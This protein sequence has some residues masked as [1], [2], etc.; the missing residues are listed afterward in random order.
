MTEREARSKGHEPVP[1]DPPDPAWTSCPCGYSEMVTPIWRPY[2]GRKGWVLA[3]YFGVKCPHHGWASRLLA[4]KGTR[5]SFYS[6]ADELME[7][8][9]N[10]VSENSPF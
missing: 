6:I 5:P 8:G 10:G 7:Y 1:E 4:I 2:L 3:W 9:S